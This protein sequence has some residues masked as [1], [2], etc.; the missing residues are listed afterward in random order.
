MPSGVGGT[1]L[2]YVTFPGAIYDYSSTAVITNVPLY[3]VN[4][5]DVTNLNAGFWITSTNGEFTVPASSM[6]NVGWLYVDEKGNV[7]P[8]P[9]AT[10]A[11]P[12]VGRIAFWVD[13]EASKINLN[14]AGTPSVTTPPVPDF[15]TSVSNEVDL[16]VL[17]P[18][19]PYPFVGAIHNRQVP[20]GPGFTTIEEVKL[21][22]PSESDFTANRFS[23]TAYSSDANYPN[24]T[25]DL[26]A[27][28]VQRRAVSALTE[29]I[30]I[31][32]TPPTNI[33]VYARLAD[34]TGTTL[35]EIYGSA[36]AA[37]YPVAG[38][39]DGLK[40]IIANIIAYQ[41][42][43]NSPAPPDGGPSGALPI[44]LGLAKTPYIN[45]VQVRYDVSLDPVDSNITN[46]TRTVS[47]E[48]FYPYNDTD[49][50]TPAPDSIQVS[51]LTTYGAVLATAT[52]TVPAADTFGTTAGAQAYRL[53]QD[54][55]KDILPIGFTPGTPTVVVNYSRGVT[56]L[57]YSQVVMPT[58]STT[59]TKPADKAW[60]GAE[61]NDPCA[62]E[63]SAIAGEWTAYTDASTIPGTLGTPNTAYAP[64]SGDISKLVM[65]GG[66]MNSIGELGY[67]HLPHTAATAN[68]WQ[69][70]RLQPQLVAEKPAIP[71]WAM[72]DLFTTA[73]P[74]PQTSGRI[75]INSFINPGLAPA[76]PIRP[77]LVPLSALLNSVP[78]L[79]GFAAL[80]IY[81]DNSRTSTD[82]YGMKDPATGDPV[83]DTIGE[84][85]EIPALANSQ[86]L[87]A[88]KEQAIRRI[89]NLI[90][91]RSSTFTIWVMAQSIKDVDKNGRYNPPPGLNNSDFITGEVRAQAVVERYEDPL[92]SAPKFRVRYFRY[93][94]N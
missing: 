38:T 63:D 42:P 22:D 21:A 37:K 83:F 7:G 36:F 54:V 86:T 34:S 45:E 15:G 51:G 85:C 65:R 82:T 62:N 8:T 29:A 19:S 24:Y 64:P 5:V 49:V 40:Q 90:T 88:D 60:Q 41:Q 52:L 27:F 61:A 70:L 28:G 66:P 31:Q 76:A 53:Y 87:E 23:I 4:A 35:G 73:T 78:V 9:L 12:L 93:L 18:P 33:S 80:A 16:G 57:D 13:D 84:V 14:T 3:S 17:F 92:G 2:N 30:D 25:D 74:V 94:Y 81:N 91:V 39:V 50:Y 68:L 1:I 89:A 56:R 58:I 26:D 10:P 79:S 77:R 48:L 55:Q 46:L 75:N 71:D 59:L 44:Y 47:V 69:H 32:N 72:L 6:F 67:I 11:N 20:S 43:I